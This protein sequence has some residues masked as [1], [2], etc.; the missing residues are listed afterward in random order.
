M[1]EVN[2]IG[3]KIQSGSTDIFDNRYYEKKSKHE[4]NIKIAAKN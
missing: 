3:L 1:T 2:P 4:L